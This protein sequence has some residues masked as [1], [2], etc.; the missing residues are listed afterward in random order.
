MKPL[1]PNRANQLTQI[2]REI[3]EREEVI[4]LQR[5]RLAEA[6]SSLLCEVIFQGEALLKVKQIL[7]HGD[8]MP[9]VATHCPLI[10]HATANTYMRLH[11]KFANSTKEKQAQVL[12]AASMREAMLLLCAPEKPTEGEAKKAPSWPHWLQCTNFVGKF[13]KILKSNP[14]EKWPPEG[15]ENLRVL[16]EPVAAQVWP[17]KFRDRAE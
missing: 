10:S 8:F 13:A 9:W 2:A 7:K 12:D 14:L 5:R 11:W 17:E 15:R 16:L 4:D 6:G 1:L 3:N